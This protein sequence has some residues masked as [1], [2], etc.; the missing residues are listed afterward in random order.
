MATDTLNSPV[1]R[2]ASS[3]SRGR[4]AAGGRTRALLVAGAVAGPLWAA[5]SVGQAVTREGFE[6]TVHPMSML[7]NGSLGWLQITN[8][9]VAGVLA[10]AGAAGVRRVPYGATGGVW[11]PRLLTVYGLGMIAAGVF[12]MDPSHGFAGAPEGAPDSMSA[13]AVAHLVAGMVTFG[14]LIA[15]NYV[16][17][18]RFSRA[19]RRGAAVASR[20]AGTALLFGNVWGMSGGPAGS[21][22]LATGSITAM[23]WIAAVTARLAR[24]SV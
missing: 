11:F 2:V 8:F 13:P 24:R 6:L 19:R 7:A 3:A 1:S 15:A 14:A 16:L 4:A 9:V 23:V 18:R 10:L 5:V 22:V 21:L 20:I 12:V 17:G